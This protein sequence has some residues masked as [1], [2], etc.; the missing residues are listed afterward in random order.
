[1]WVV[2]HWRTSRKGLYIMSLSGIGRVMGTDQDGVRCLDP[3]PSNLP[4]TE[5]ELASSL[6]CR[7][8]PSPSST[9][10]QA[11]SAMARRH[12]SQGLRVSRFIMPGKSLYLPR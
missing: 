11:H 4:G 9:P 3:L 8:Y 5:R 6:W 7:Y 2:S 1:M 12:T 10:A